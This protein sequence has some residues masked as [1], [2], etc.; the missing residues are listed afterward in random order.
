[1][2]VSKFS[3]L[4]LPWLWGPI[5]L[6][7]NLSLRWGLKQSCSPCRELSNGMLQATCKRGN[8][9]D[10]WLLVVGSQIGNLIPDLSFGHN[11]C[12]RCPNGSYEPISDIYVPRDFQWYNFFPNPLGL[13]PCNYSL[14]IWES[15]KTPI[16][17]SGSLGSIKCDSGVSLSAHP[18]ASPCFGRELKAKVATTYNPLV[19]LI[20]FPS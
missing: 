13:D 14:K 2:G 5:T 10:S 4:G 19:K 15:T 20:Y 1:V 3:Q 8:Q 17:Q 18:L 16:F 12:F 11:L 9:G 7:V 6:C